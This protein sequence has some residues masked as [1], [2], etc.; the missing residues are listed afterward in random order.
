MGNW[1]VMDCIAV[2]SASTD[3]MFRNISRQ[4]AEEARRAGVNYMVRWEIEPGAAGTRES[5]RL[6]AMLAGLDAKGVRPR[7]DKIQRAKPLAAQSEAGNV[8]LIRGSWNEAWLT[9]MHSIPDGNHDDIMDG[10]SGAFNAL[11]HK[12]PPPKMVRYA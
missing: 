9:H 3:K 8:K 6:T 7:G 11:T 1:Y 5:R 2:Q 4:D 10:S 12:R